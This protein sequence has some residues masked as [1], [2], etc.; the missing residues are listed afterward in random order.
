M[1]FG[2]VSCGGGDCVLNLVRKIAYKLVRAAWWWARFK[3]LKNEKEFNRSNGRTRY[4]A[5][6]LGE[7]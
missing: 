4:E 1:G 3:G 7:S 6:H 5:T 2:V